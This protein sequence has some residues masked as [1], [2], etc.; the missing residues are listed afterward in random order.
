M[1]T[2]STIP[3]DAFI[4][5]FKAFMDQAVRQAPPEEEPIFRQRLRAHFG[6][7][8]TQLPVLSERFKAPITPIFSLGPEA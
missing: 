5:S 8:P 3:P 2:D 1:S 6:H 7:E 4:T